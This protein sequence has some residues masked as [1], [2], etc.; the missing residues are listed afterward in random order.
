[1]DYVITKEEITLM[2]G[3]ELLTY[4]YVV[5]CDIHSLEFSLTHDGISEGSA[6]YQDMVLELK[7]LRELHEDLM[8]EVVIRKNVGE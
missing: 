3:D 8:D 5:E 1:M 6:V 4:L 2:K 7:E